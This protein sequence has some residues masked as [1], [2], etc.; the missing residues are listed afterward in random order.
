[1]AERNISHSINSQWVGCQQQSAQPALLNF[2][3]IEEVMDMNNVFPALLKWKFA[4]LT[5]AA[6][7][8]SGC[9]IT[10]NL[11]VTTDKP[12][13]V[14]LA[15]DKPINL[16]VEK[17]IDLKLDAGVAVTKLPPIRVTAGDKK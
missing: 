8:L 11:H 17:P 15:V 7:T 12:I 9:P 2:L 6:F 1:L 10:V 13:A 16:V 3:I 4:I 5:S 14:N